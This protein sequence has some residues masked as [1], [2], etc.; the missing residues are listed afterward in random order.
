MLTII[1]QSAIVIATIITADVAVTAT[2]SRMTWAF[3][4]EQG[5]PFS[6]YLSRVSNI[7]QFFQ[8]GF[9]LFAALIHFALLSTTFPSADESST[10]SP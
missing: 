1:A 10:G 7:H 5:L 4:R 3:A 6:R 8:S 9:P 2:A